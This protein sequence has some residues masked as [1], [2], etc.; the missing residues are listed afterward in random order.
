MPVRS[1]MRTREWSLLALL[2][3][4]AGPAAADRGG[5]VIHRFDTQL[6]VEPNATLTVEER[7]EVEFTEP[8]HGL[9][10]TI[11]VRYTDPRGYA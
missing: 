7:L 2:A 9:Y 10:R 8:R 6:T 3:L 1:L 11:P 5:Y 4:S